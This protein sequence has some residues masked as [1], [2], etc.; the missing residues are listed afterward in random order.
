[1]ISKAVL[2]KPWVSHRGK[3]YPVGTTFKLV[4]IFRDTKLALHDFLIPGECYGLV[5]FPTKIFV[6]LTK[7]ELEI[8]NRRKRE[9]EE[10]IR[11]HNKYY[12]ER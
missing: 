7:K 2:K 6:R 3:K 1:M 4:K 5:V 11:K 10:H 9:Y 8:K 12:K